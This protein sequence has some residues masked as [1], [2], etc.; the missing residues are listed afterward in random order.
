MIK[1]K[2]LISENKDPHITTIDNNID[3]LLKTDFSEAYQLKT[4]SKIGLYRAVRRYRGDS[5]I[6]DRS[7]LERTSRATSN[8]YTVL[9]DF[10][11][12]WKGYPKRSYSV[13]ALAT[14]N[15]EF[16]ASEMI[17]Q[18]G[19]FFYRVFPK[20]GAK[21]CVSPHTDA[22]LAF[23]Y[24]QH[25]LGM[26]LVEFD[27]YFDYAMKDCVEEGGGGK[28]SNLTTS[29]LGY[30]VEKWQKYVT[31]DLIIN[32]FERRKS[33]YIS[34]WITSVIDDIQIHFNGDWI[35]YFDGLLD[36]IKNGFQLMNITDLKSMPSSSEV[37]TDSKCLL[38]KI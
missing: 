25:R 3:G 34:H 17:Q 28:Y 18:Y 15:D 37:W 19:H 16:H 4:N 29:T 35:E 24:I 23:G 33:H 26:M 2:H 14:K 36:P 9:M 10:V 7:Q 21:V 31:K 8:F 27:S 11:P 20:N 5:F 22:I 1:L 38:Q 32:H 6:V 13:I 12:S 30:A